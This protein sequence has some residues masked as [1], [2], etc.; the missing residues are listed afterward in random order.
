M[1]IF[2]GLGYD[3]SSSTIHNWTN[4]KFKKYDIK[5]NFSEFSIVCYSTV[6]L[7]CSYWPFRWSPWCRRSLSHVEQWELQPHLRLFTELVGATLINGWKPLCI[8]TILH[9][10]RFIWGGQFHDFATLI[11]GSKLKPYSKTIVSLCLWNMT[12]YSLALSQ[13]HLLG[14]SSLALLCCF[15]SVH[16]L[17]ALS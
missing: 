8:P 1:T 16:S 6:A 12:H 15:C 13:V 2:P 4:K 10:L 5:Y 14:V 9:L 17:T 3:S 11:W 7:H